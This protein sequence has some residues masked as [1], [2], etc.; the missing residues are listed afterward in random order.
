MQLYAVEASLDSVF[1][2][3][4]VETNI[5]FD[6]RNRKFSWNIRLARLRSVLTEGDRAGSNEIKVAFL[7]EDCNICRASKSP[8]LEEDVRAVGVDSIRDLW[9]D[10]EENQQ[11]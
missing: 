7:P 3:L 10:N 5:F 2:C 11:S 9:I 1:C 8:K 4:G 6:L